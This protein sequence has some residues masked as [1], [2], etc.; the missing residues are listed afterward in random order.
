MPEIKH[1]FTAGKM[2]KDLDERLVPNGQYREALNVQ[3]RT[4]DSD[5]DG[6]GNAGVIQNLQGNSHISDGSDD[7]DGAFNSISYVTLASGTIPSTKIIGSI[8]DEKNDK[9]Y[10]FAAAPDIDKTTVTNITQATS[11]T[12]RVFVDS[13]VEVDTVT[14]NARSIFVDR[15]AVMGQKQDVFTLSG[16]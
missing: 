14:Q 16:Q 12:Q 6:V 7:N 3:V 4:T 11:P 5:S 2:N 8:A 9:A 10:F 1:T 13:I 15:F